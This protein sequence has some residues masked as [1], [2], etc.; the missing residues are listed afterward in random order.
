MNELGEVRYLDRRLHVMRRHNIIAQLLAFSLSSIVAILLARV[1][2][3]GGIFNLIGLVTAW[4]LD[5]F[6]G[7]GRPFRTLIPALYWVAL[8]AETRE[9]TGS[10]SFPSLLAYA[11]IHPAWLVAPVALVVLVVVRDFVARD[12]MEDF[13]L[14]VAL[15]LGL[16]FLANAIGTFVA[17]PWL[18]LAVAMAG[19]GFA[20]YVTAR[21]WPRARPIG[22]FATAGVCFIVVARSLWH[23][24][25]VNLERGSLFGSAILLFADAMKHLRRESGGP[26]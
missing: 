6:L 16:F 3:I 17:F 21:K 12:L 10:A 24:E 25:P 2:F 13:E 1:I 8:T 4:L 19:V 23:H 11:I 9:N 15:C 7:S 5:L 14:L 20:F 22:E 26:S 18:L